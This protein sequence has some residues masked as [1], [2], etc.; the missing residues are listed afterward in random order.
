TPTFREDPSRPSLVRFRQSV[1]GSFSRAAG[2]RGR[3]PRG[4]ARLLRVVAFRDRE[5]V[6]TPKKGREL[7]SMRPGLM[8]VAVSFGMIAT[9][10]ADAKADADANA[11]ANAN[12]N[13]KA[14]ADADANANANANAD[15]NA[16]A[17]AD[18]EAKAKAAGEQDVVTA[19][20]REHRE[21]A[22]G[23]SVFGT[24]LIY[25]KVATGASLFGDV[26]WDTRLFGASFLRPSLR[27]AFNRTSES[28]KPSLAHP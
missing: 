15:A 18:A 22:V 8:G 12:A 17:D 16:K 23:G 19:A 11:N 13:A 20:P 5:G 24:T 7:N 10:K 9:A 1:L 25:D 3:D 28:T 2:G 27:L 14:D 4:K 26:R 21:W 6:S